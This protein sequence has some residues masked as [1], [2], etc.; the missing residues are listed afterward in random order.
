ME[1]PYNPGP[2][3]KEKVTTYEPLLAQ[4]QRE[5][6]AEGHA[7]AVA[8]IVKWLRQER[9]GS[10]TRDGWLALRIEVNFGEASDR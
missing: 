3:G 8:E 2:R 5:A 6:W 9:A 1:N 4:R 10:T 7:A